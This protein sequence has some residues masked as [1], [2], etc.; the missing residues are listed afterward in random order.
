MVAAARSEG[1]FRRRRGVGEPSDLDEVLQLHQR[2]RRDQHLVLGDRLAGS[3]GNPL[4][5]TVVES[6]HGVGVEVDQGRHPFDQ[7][8]WTR[9]SGSPTK[10]SRTLNGRSS[11]SEPLFL[12]ETVRVRASRK[13]SRLG[14][15]QALTDHSETRGTASCRR[16]LGG[17]LVEHR[18]EP[19]LEV[20]H[21]DDLLHCSS[22]AP[23][24]R[25]GERERDR[26]HGTTGGRVAVGD[27]TALGLGEDLDQRQAE[28]QPFG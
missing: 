28:A 23:S 22:S 26:E 18:L 2:H 5:L 14:V 27:G 21:A 3:G 24:G 25:V 16:H 1:Q 12:L 9:S 13:D 6:R 8:I 19:A 4:G 7:S 20:G 10:H 15:R 11:P 17:H